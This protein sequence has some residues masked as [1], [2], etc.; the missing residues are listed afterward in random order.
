MGY[1]V[2]F[3]SGIISVNTN[4]KLS[5]LWIDLPKICMEKGYQLRTFKPK[6][7]ALENLFLKLVT[8]QA[9]EAMQA[10]DGIIPANITKEEI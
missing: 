2:E 5:Q 6:H 1:N 10:Q 8:N 7:D 9:L 3:D 4:G